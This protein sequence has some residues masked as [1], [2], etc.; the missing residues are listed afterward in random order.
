M[1]MINCL[2]EVY[3]NPTEKGARPVSWKGTAACIVWADLKE[4]GQLWI[5]R[6]MAGF[7]AAPIPG[8]EIFNDWEVITLQTIFDE[9]KP[10]ETQLKD[11][12]SQLASI[13]GSDQKGTSP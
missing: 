3:N 13:S 6:T 10:F 12:E 4:D 7:Q 11:L 1:D 8:D 9:Q 5:V 2:K